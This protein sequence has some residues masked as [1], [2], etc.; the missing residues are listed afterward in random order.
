[1]Y[2]IKANVKKIEHIVQL[3]TYFWTEHIL[4]RL[5]GNWLSNYDNNLSGELLYIVTEDFFRI[6]N[7]LSSVA[8][9]AYFFQRLRLAKTY[10]QFSTHLFPAFCVAEYSFSSFLVQSYLSS[11]LSRPSYSFFFLFMPNLPQNQMV[12]P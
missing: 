8:T 11:V 10:F 2:I 4:R 7:L 12:V 9:H 5:L 3:N 1:M 6:D